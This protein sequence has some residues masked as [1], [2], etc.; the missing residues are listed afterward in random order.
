MRRHNSARLLIAADM[1]TVLLPV[2]MMMHT[3]RILLSKSKTGLQGTAAGSISASGNE[4]R[5]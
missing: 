2:G 4:A 5:R 1:Y 3:I